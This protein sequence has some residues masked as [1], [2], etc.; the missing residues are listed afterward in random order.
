VPLNSLLLSSLGIALATGLS[1]MAPKSSFILMV[2][3]SSFGALFTWMMIFVTH[4]FFRRFHDRQGGATLSFRM[5]Y[6][7]V[8]TLAGA[9]LMLAILV[10]TAFTDAFRMTLVFGLPFLVVLTVVYGLFFRKSLSVQRA[11]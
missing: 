11:V 10:T 4:Y 2:A 9:L 5:K 7:P 8:T 3:I 6:F 1:V